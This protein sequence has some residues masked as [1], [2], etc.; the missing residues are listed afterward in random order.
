MW[1]RP[2]SNLPANVRV[3]HIGEGPALYPGLVKEMMHQEGP[4]PSSS[5]SISAATSWQAISLAYETTRLENRF[6]FFFPSKAYDPWNIVNLSLCP[7]VF[8]VEQFFSSRTY[9]HWTLPAIYVFWEAK[10]QFDFS[11]IMRSWIWNGCRK[12]TPKGCCVTFI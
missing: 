8:S 6:F 11:A 2:K 9:T 1:C 4:Q 3:M 10:T 7:S 12:I 5:W